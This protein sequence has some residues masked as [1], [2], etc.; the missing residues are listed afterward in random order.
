MGV[1]C[2]SGGWSASHNHYN[3]FSKKWK[4]FV[5]TD[6]TAFVPQSGRP[7]FAGFGC[8]AWQ[9]FKLSGSL[10]RIPESNLKKPNFCSERT[11]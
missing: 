10:G 9:E 7:Y 3:Y 2:E 8:P 11:Q 5:V 1:I 4:N 6:L